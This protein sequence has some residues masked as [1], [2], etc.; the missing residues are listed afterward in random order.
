MVNV[1]LPHLETLKLHSSERWSESIR[2]KNVTKLSFEDY[3][4][5]NNLHFPRLQSLYIGTIDMDSDQNRFLSEHNQL[6]HLHV[7]HSSRD[8]SVFQQFTA[9]QFDLEELTLQTIFNPGFSTGAILEFLRTRNKMQKLTLIMYNQERI[10][11][12]Q[13]QLKHE[14]NATTPQYSSWFQFERNTNAQR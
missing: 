13:V 14:W 10:D 12:L 6:R 3:T 4:K 1:F 9:H 7:R 5:T 2:F 11:E 8:D